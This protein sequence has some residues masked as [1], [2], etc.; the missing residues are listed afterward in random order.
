MRVGLLEGGAFLSVDE[1]AAVK[2]Q[3]PGT[4]LEVISADQRGAYRALSGAGRFDPQQLQPFG[5]RL[6]V[7]STAEDEEEAA[8]YVQRTLEVAGVPV[9]TVRPIPSS[10][11]NAFI[12][13]VRERRQPE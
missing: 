13:L 10:L 9:E 5:D 7:I 12:S 3:V 4:V 6:H 2:R 8:G 11:E 1:P